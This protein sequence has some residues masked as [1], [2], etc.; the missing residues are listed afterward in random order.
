[1]LR[2][3][4]GTLKTD[5]G[6]IL[7]QSINLDVKA[8][9]LNYLS[10]PNGIGKTSLINAILGIQHSISPIQRSFKDFVYLPQIENKEFLLPITLEDVSLEGNLLKPEERKTPWNIASGGQRK[11]AMLEKTLKS[12]KDLYVLDEPYN[13][14]DTQSIERINTIINDMVKQGSSILIVSHSKPEIGSFISWE[15]SEWK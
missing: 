11:K 12:K 14:L 8:G 4:R 7:F 2:I 9:T 10:G 6:K 5:D 15:A 1:M 13:H 3:D